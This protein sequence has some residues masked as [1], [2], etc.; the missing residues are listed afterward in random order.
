MYGWMYVYIYIYVKE[1]TGAGRLLEAEEV[2]ELR[3]EPRL[4]YRKE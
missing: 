3:R 2:E 4:S 1:D